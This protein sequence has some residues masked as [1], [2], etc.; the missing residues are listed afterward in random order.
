MSQAQGW[1][2][3]DGD[4][5]YTFFDAINQADGDGV[6]A[7]VTSVAR[8]T[9]GTLTPRAAEFDSIGE[10]DS[11]MELSLVCLG[12]HCCPAKVGQAGAPRICGRPKS[13]CTVPGHKKAAGVVEPGWYIS[14][15]AKNAGAFEQPRL[16][17]ERDGGP[18]TS[19]GAAFLIDG[20][21]LF[22]L[23]KGR[24]LLAI[25]AFLAAEKAKAEVLH[26]EIP[27]Y[28]EEPEAEGLSLESYEQISFSRAPGV[29]FANP[30]TA[31][32]A[33]PRMWGEQRPALRQV[34]A[35]VA[36]GEAVTTTATTTRAPTMGQV[37]TAVGAQDLAEA[38]PAEEE[39]A[40]IRESSPPPRSIRRPFYV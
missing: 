25:E 26:V 22:K 17:I 32:T 9:D 23:P 21:A 31:S 36:T 33:A 4:F 30:P 38:E 11:K 14:A 37:A 15:G 19:R 20:D 28:D 7:V 10:W 1:S 13:D 6:V 29:S 40:G 5:P 8:T 3:S 18:I 24:W 12:A 39:I 2:P 35:A 16:P 34:P 27:E